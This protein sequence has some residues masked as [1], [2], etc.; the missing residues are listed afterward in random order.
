MN[1]CSL[2]PG[3]PVLLTGSCEVGRIIHVWYVASHDW[4]SCYVAFFGY[5][6]PPTDGSEP[7]CKPYVLHYL[8]SSLKLLTEEEFQAYVPP[9]E[10]NDNCMLK[11]GI[12]EL[13]DCH[14]LQIRMTDHEG[15]FATVTWKDKYG[16]MDDQGVPISEEQ[17]AQLIAGQDPWPILLACDPELEVIRDKA[18]MIEVTNPEL[19]YDEPDYAH[20]CVWR[21]VY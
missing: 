9:T 10:H 20:L 16:D 15:P 19:E 21:D 1:I 7:P 4:H 18:T 3:D 2:K 8:D 11:M 13:C 12:R 17:H 14:L 6:P 5:H